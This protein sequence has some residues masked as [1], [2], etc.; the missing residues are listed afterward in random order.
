MGLEY[1]L[2]RNT[3][4][5]LLR[6]DKLI[7][8]LKDRVDTGEILFRCAV[9]LSY[10]TEAEQEGVE[11]VLSAND[12]KVVTNKVQQL[13]SYS[14]SC[15]LN[16][17]ITHQILSGEINKEAKKI[18]APAIKIKSKV[19]SKFFA[20]DTKVSEIERV[21]EEALERYFQVNSSVLR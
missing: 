7:K 13:R 2:S 15:E 12:F 3:V 11:Q 4:A 6:I 5:R 1:G 21:V 19:Y 10:L 20:A 14:A 17:Q 18:T 16:E 9:D 8:Y